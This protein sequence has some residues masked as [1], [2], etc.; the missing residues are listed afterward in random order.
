[1]TVPLDTLEQQVI[2]IVVG[3]QKRA[4]GSVTLDTTFEELALDSL[5]RMDLLFEFEDTFKVEIPD[6]VAHRLRTVRD[7]VESLRAVGAGT[8]RPDAPHDP[9]T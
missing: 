4:A 5:D 1:V 7:A 8:P 2:D 3:T 6:D 9:A